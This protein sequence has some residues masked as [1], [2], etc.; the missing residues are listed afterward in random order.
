MNSSKKTLNIVAIATAVAGKEKA[1]R[2]L[3]EKL[4]HETQKEAGCIRFELNQVIDNGRVLV[5]VESWA[6]EEQWKAHMQGRAIQEFRSA[7][8]PNMIEDFT[9][10]RMEKVAGTQ[11]AIEM[12]P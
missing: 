7:G 1:L 10:L 5:F 8:G 2:A 4:V 12:S 3:Q 9:L 11:A 6:S